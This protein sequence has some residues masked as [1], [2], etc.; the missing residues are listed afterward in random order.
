MN[1]PISIEISHKVLTVLGYKL[2]PRY[3]TDDLH[4]WYAWNN[5]WNVACILNS[6]NYS[7]LVLEMPTIHRW[8]PYYLIVFLIGILDLPLKL[9]KIL[10][11]PHGEI[12]Q[13]GAQHKSMSV[14]FFVGVILGHCFLRWLIPSPEFWAEVYL[15]VI[16]WVWSFT[17]DVEDMLFAVRWAF[18]PILYSIHLLPLF[19]LYICSSEHFPHISEIIYF[20]TEEALIYTIFF[21]IV[22][23]FCDCFYTNFYVFLEK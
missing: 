16:F 23:H 13:L 10:L 22:L 15:D 6:K 2:L 21:T 17:S 9:H 19:I 20:L 11:V 18:L 5:S 7:H 14:V 4:P 12:F 3:A 1:H 8:I